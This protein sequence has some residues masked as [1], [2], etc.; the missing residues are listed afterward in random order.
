MDKIKA[1]MLRDRTMDFLVRFFPQYL[2]E[3]DRLLEGVTYLVISEVMHALS[4][5]HQRFRAQI[6]CPR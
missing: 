2:A 3:D 6:V 1:A 4:Q 5:Q